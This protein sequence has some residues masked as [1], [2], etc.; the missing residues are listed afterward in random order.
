MFFTLR[1]NL[2]LNISF[3]SLNI[4]TASYNSNLVQ[5][6]NKQMNKALRLS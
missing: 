4:G 1:S 2:C 3:W 6:T 5:Q